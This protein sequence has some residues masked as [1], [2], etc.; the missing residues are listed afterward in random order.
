MNKD[1]KS[2]LIQIFA[3]FI[4]VVGAKKSFTRDTVF[5]ASFKFK[6]LSSPSLQNP[7]C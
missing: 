6:H 1:G 5:L 7:N 2:N 3:V 4:S